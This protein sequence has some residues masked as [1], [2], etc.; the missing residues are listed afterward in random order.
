MKFLSKTVQIPWKTV[1]KSSIV[2]LLT[3]ALLVVVYIQKYRQL[4]QEAVRLQDEW[5]ISV[6]SLIDRKNDLAF[7]WN[8]LHQKGVPLEQQKKEKEEY[9][10]ALHTYIVAMQGWLT[11]QKQF[12]K[13]WDTQIILS[14]RFGDAYVALYKK[15]RRDLESNLLAVDYTNHLGR[16]DFK[17]YEDR[18]LLGIQ[19]QEEANRELQKKAKLSKGSF[20]IRWLFIKK[21]ASK[22]KE[23]YVPRSSLSFYE[24][25]DMKSI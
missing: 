10:E 15:Y 20:D 12:L 9:L 7:K 24:R 8:D 1:I 16:D 25:Y 19:K 13:K 14:G 18:L 17:V 22:C 21:S 6:D 11:K 2:A 23:D 5:C 3:L 4:I